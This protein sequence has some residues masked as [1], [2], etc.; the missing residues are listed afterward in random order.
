[1]K[2]RFSNGFISGLVG[3]IV[4][5][6]INF[7]SRALDL[8]TLVWA[9]YMGI[10]LLNRRPQGILEMVFLLGIQLVFLGLLGAIFALILPLLTS[11][12]DIFKGH[13]SG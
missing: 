11:K 13:Y 8:N 3:G 4:P 7:G 1:M 9:D 5:L 12:R 10:F 6:S 2:D